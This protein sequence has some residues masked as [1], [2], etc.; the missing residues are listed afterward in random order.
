MSAANQIEQL[1]RREA[2]LCAALRS[3]SSGPGAIPITGALFSP[4]HGAARPEGNHITPPRSGGRRECRREARR[5][6]ARRR[7]WLG[8]RPALVA[9]S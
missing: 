5:L 4:A 6:L 8:L 9:L 1:R 2:G 7:L 3:G